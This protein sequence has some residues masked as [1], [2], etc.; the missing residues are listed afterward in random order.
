MDGLSN[1]LAASN[2]LLQLELGNDA[3]GEQDNEDHEQGT[4]GTEG[5]TFMAA[6]HKN[7]DNAA[8]IYIRMMIRI[9]QGK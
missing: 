9:G 5:K 4:A 7:L 8:Q 1:R 3:Y 2:Y 6:P